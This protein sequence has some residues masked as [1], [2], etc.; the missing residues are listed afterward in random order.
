MS[1]QAENAP[2]QAA[3]VPSPGGLPG[4]LR[5]H[6]L[7]LVAYELEPVER[8][9]REIFEIEPCFHSDLFGGK[10][11]IHNAVFEIGGSFLEV[12]ALNPGVE[13]QSAP[14]GRYLQRRGGNGGYMVIFECNDVE[15]RKAYLRERGMRI[16]F[17]PHHDGFNEIQLHPSDTGGSLVSLNET[18]GRHGLVG[19]YLPAGRDWWKRARRSPSALEIAGA[20]LQSANPRALAERWAGILEKPVVHKSAELSEMVL[21]LGVLRFVPDRDGRGE[22]LGAM[23]L[24][25]ADKAPV[26]ARARQQGVRVD[27]DTVEVCGIRIHLIEP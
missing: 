20:E 24:V 18:E 19:A 2:S 11:G 4:A 12:V 21:D 14:A 8:Q 6:Q 26:L 25:V 1:T 16:V 3:Q 13:P 15:R 27:G 9:L 5:L 10:F 23:D 22:G 7:C 17:S